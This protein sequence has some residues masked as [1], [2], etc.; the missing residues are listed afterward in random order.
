[1]TLIILYHRRTHSPFELA[2]IRQIWGRKFGFSVS[3]R[4]HGKAL[5][6]EQ[7]GK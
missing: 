7:K 5:T 4:L 2:R 3:G 1:M 6:G